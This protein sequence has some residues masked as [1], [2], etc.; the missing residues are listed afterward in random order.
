[1]QWCYR[2]NV[3]G[4][5][6]ERE[7]AREPKSMTE[8]TAKQALVTTGATVTFEA[9]IRAVLEPRFLETLAQHGYE[10]VVVQYGRSERSV[11]VIRAALGALGDR[12]SVASERDEPDTGHTVCGTYH[13][14]VGG[15]SLKC[16]QF[17]VRLIERYTGRSELVISHAGTGSIMDTLRVRAGAAQPARRPPR[18]IVMVNTGLQDNHQTEIAQAFESLGVVTSVATGAELTDAV[19]RT[20]R[21]AAA[22]AAPTVVLP[23]AC[24]GAV[25]AVVADELLPD[26]A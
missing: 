20:E 4:W 22:A 15:V 10:R 3:W 11:T 6:T 26:S 23:E 16:I 24:G 8:G 5:D 14:D 25:E 13:S 12:V 9:L 17:D 1:M 18:L 2:K 19:V 7:I 21:A